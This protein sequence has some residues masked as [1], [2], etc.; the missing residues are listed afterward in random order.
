ML[1]FSDKNSRIDWALGLTAVLI[2]I[3]SL[4]ISHKL[5]SDLQQEERTRME[6]WAEAMRALDLADENTDLSLVL[7]VINGNH[8]IPVIVLDSD[9]N[10][11][12]IRN[13]DKHHDDAELTDIAQEWRR[14]GNVIRVEMDS[15]DYM[16][17]CYDESTMLRRLTRY[18][19]IQLLVVAAFMV[20][21]IIAILAAKRAE[22]NKVWV[23]LSKETAHQL[24]TPISSLMAWVEVLRENYPDDELIPELDQDVKRLERIAERFSK[25]GSAPELKPTDVTVVI[26]NVVRY[27]KRRT[28]HH[29]TITTDLPD[30]P[31]TATINAP[32]FEW[33]IENLC[34]NAVDAMHGNGSLTLTAFEERGKAVVEVSD[35]GCG[36]PPNKFDSVFRPGYTTKQRGWGLG[37]SLA[38]RI[39]REYHRGSIF[40]KSSEIGVGTTFRVEV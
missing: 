10:V 32:L 11:Q 7:N 34:K 13:I 28:S 35:T 33:V 1:L 4:V 37:L 18:P 38:N 15:H 5:V 27:I 22:Q 14:E 36:I 23:G 26:N 30:S 19:Y 31:L 9:G 16:E 24:G 2:A 21:C 6:L 3:A 12:T 29:V 8:T 39:I 20:V 17:V 40:V 25:I